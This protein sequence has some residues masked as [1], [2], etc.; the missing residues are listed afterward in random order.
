M[1]VKC[2]LQ[3]LSVQHYRTIAW[4]KMP[5]AEFTAVPA[6]HLYC[7]K[8]TVFKQV[9][10]RK[11][12]LNL[13]ITHW[14]STWFFFFCYTVLLSACAVFW[15]QCPTQMSYTNVLHKGAGVVI[16]LIKSISGVI[17]MVLISVKVQVSNV[18]IRLTL[19]L[20]ITYYYVELLQLIVVCNIWGFIL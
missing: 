12:W 6:L 8:F 7:L 13:P 18:T 9:S 3:E 11:L 20:L 17:F 1:Y 4:A 19:H 15:G 16:W 5:E 2:P 10:C 14:L